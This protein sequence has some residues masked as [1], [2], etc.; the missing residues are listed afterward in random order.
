ME[1][2]VNELAHKLGIDPIKLRE[3]NMVREG[4]LLTNYFG[5]VTNSCNLDKC[6]AKVKE[7]IRWDE[8]YPYV[9]TG[10]LGRNGDGDARLRNRWC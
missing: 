4:D 6:V 2:A 3:M 8:K 9:K 10:P 5:E 7:M 1:S